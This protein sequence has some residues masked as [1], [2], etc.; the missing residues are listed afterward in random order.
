M[1]PSLKRACALGIWMG[2]ALGAAG[3][4]VMGCAPRWDPA[5]LL[6]TIEEAEAG[7]E[8]RRALTTCLGHPEIARA[9]GELTRRCGRAAEHLAGSMGGAL[10]AS[11]ASVALRALAAWGNRSLLAEA[12]DRSRVVVP[13]GEFI[14]GSDTGRANERPEHWVYLDEYAIHRFEVTNVQYARFVDATGRG[15]PLYWVEGSYPE[16][17]DDL[18]VVGVK[19]E[20]AAAYCEWTGGRLPTEAEW[21][22]ACRGAAGT[23]YP[24][25]DAWDG[26]RANIGFGHERATG[27]FL[28][29][30]Y[31]TLQAGPSAGNVGLRPVG[32]FP[33]G[34]SSSGVLDLVGNA[35]EWVADWYN[36]DGYWTMPAINPIGE[37]PEWNRSVRGS[38]WFFPM[39][40]EDEAPLWSRCSARNSS[41]ASIDPR[42]G[43]RCA[44]PTP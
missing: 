41:H 3:A 32:S 28:T 23:I 4:L 7:G 14:M 19:W 44:Y 38:S 15:T 26:S 37:G 17:Q 43:F 36:W 42:V 33:H 31:P 40:M 5:G 24:W 12:L 20:Q 8:W 29:A 1:R 16:G 22:K 9:G 2:L 34:A 21:E 18:A 13:A 10:E 11:E 30:L 6:L 35:A 27:A 25:G 39:G